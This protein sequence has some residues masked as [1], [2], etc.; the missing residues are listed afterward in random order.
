MAERSTAA[1][2]GTQE[3]PVR[4][5]PYVILGKLGEGGMGR[6]YLA[7]QT[8][9]VRRRVALKLVRAGLESEGVLARFESER[10]ALALLNHPA[11]AHVYD[12][13]TT[14]EGQPYFAMEYVPGPTITEYA[15][16]RRLSIADRLSMFVEVCEGVQH[17]H[18]KG[19]IHRDLKASNILVSTEGP[20]P[21]PKIIDFGVA[22]TLS[23]RLTE[24]SLH[25]L[26]WQVVGTI[27][28]MSPEQ[29]SSGPVDVD[30][31]T[32]VYALGV[33]LY[34]LLVGMLPFGT[35]ES[36]SYE[37]YLRRIRIEEPKRPA[38]RLADLGP[39]L[40][41]VAG[42]SRSQPA[43]LLRSVRGDLDWI[44]LKALEKDR[45]RRYGSASEL[46][47]DVRR[48]LRHEPVTARPP[49][50]LYRFRK[51][52]RRNR[53]GAIAGALVA[54]SLVLG[55]IATG[56]EMQHARS[57]ER[58]AR[59]DAEAARQ[60]TSFL[61]GI[62][63]SSDAEY[64]DDA[65][66]VQEMLG[67]IT[68]RIEAEM[69][70]RPLV[71]AS[72]LQA[73]GNRYG[74]LGLWKDA[75]RLY[76]EAYAIRKKLL[77]AE[78]LERARITYDMGRASVTLGDL[79]GGVGYLTEAEAVFR[80]KLGTQDRMVAW[81]ENDLGLG[82]AYRGDY[83][84]ALP[85]FEEA[86]RIKRIALGPNHPDYG[87]A[88]NNI[89]YIHMLLGDGEGARR[90]VAA[91]LRIVDPDGRSRVPSIQTA[92]LL[93]SMGALLERER[94]DASARPYLT[95]ALAIQ[96]SVLVGDHPDI[97]QTLATLAQVDA[98]L[99]RAAEANGEFARAVSIYEKAPKE[100]GAALAR[101]LDAY[102]RLLQ[103][104]GRSADARAARFEAESLRTALAAAPRH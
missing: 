98:H 80:K 49:S 58:Q 15:R 66:T 64:V 16:E 43:A 47:E 74:G 97:A 13:G 51:F 83:R 84:T 37:E 70:S 38:T 67:R 91:A 35:T 40:D 22:K 25:T 95:R 7:E 29:A 60:T 79:R 56:I 55:L 100:N 33:L 19:I 78:D 85:H 3:G 2:R 18:Q 101:V 87:M 1:L 69:R 12:A 20:R 5:G 96:D 92:T 4:I 52:A 42:E 26:A 59:E 89:G 31:R 24:K 41:R 88:L 73:I 68:T 62:F 63:K 86:A 76:S 14:P 46:A 104:S 30:T 45:S 77:P 11:I 54:V 72:L 8:E 71:K 10:Q 50:A 82:Y 81:C 65:V 39:D 32:D 6:V 21:L 17:A 9:P 27:A 44:T 99:G 61:L 103:S 94:R 23:A 75:L 48:H 53:T 90:Y 102:A 34:E 57:A 93:H 28:Y 36:I